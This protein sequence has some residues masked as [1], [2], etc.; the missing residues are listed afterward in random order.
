MR[1]P[2]LREAILCLLTL[3][4]RPV[5]TLVRREGTRF[6]LLLHLRDDVAA[7]AA[8]PSSLEALSRELHLPVRVLPDEEGAFLA[9]KTTLADL[10]G[11]EYV[12]RRGG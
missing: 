2:E 8:A 11:R 7:L 10:E 9:M 3:E 5:A 12:L 6:S 1:P 4:G